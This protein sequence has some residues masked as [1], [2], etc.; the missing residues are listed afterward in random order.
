MTTAEFTHELE[1]L[2][3]QIEI[4]K[5]GEFFSTA[6]QGLGLKEEDAV[7]MQNY[8]KHLMTIAEES[9]DLDDSLSTDAQAAAELAVQ[10]TRMDKGIDALADNYKN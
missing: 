6:A 2:N 5:M 7:K 3:A 4:D 8:A 9:E 10:V 1:K